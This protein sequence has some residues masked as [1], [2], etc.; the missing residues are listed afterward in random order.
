[1]K[2]QMWLVPFTWQQEAGGGRTVP[3]TRQDLQHVC[4]CTSVRL[5]HCLPCQYVGT[6]GMPMWRLPLGLRVCC[7][8]SMLCP[9]W[10]D[11]C[12]RVLACLMTE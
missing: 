11:P 9:A 4:G 3:E 6:A 7:C 12:P 5:V 2:M 10:L 1:M 8:S